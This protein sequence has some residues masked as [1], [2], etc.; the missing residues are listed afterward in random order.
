M[1]A[2]IEA[3]VGTNQYLLIDACIFLITIQL[4]NYRRKKQNGHPFV[5]VQ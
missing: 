1:F 2:M 3:R 4:L 5:V